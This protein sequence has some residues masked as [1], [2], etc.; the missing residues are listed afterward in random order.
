MTAEKSGNESSGYVVA[1]AAVA[2]CPR[3]G[4]ETCPA[5]SAGVGICASMGIAMQLNNTIKF[6]HRT[7]SLGFEKGRDHERGL[8]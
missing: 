2:V 5:E 7:I 6:V 3:S 8:S 1:E 4:A